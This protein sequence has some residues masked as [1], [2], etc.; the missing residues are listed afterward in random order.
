MNS[1]FVERVEAAFEAG[2]ESRA[3]AKATVQVGR[4]SAVDVERAIE[5]A[6]AWFQSVDQDVPFSAV[7]TFVRTR[8]PGIDPMCVRAGFE[9]RFKN[10]E[11]GHAA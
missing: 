9:K 10:G 8:C 4:A 1:A 11:N 6:W 3:A 2:L 5:A 7:V